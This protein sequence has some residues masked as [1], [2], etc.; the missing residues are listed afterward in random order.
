MDTK[1]L[2]SFLFKIK[3]FSKLKNI[4]SEVANNIAERGVDIAK[5]EYG[6]SQ[7]VIL[8][9]E[10]TKE[11]NKLQIVAQGA[12]I[13]FDE[14]GTG[15]IGE[16]T[17]RG[18]LPTEPIEFESPKGFPQRTEGWVY[19]YPNRKTKILGGWF[20]GKVFHRGQVAQAQ[21]YNTTQQLKSEMASIAEN[22]IKG[23]TKA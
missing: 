15:L 19:Y 4:S 21:M 16:G 22:T 7:R 23:L 14:F 20:A 6:H 11:P 10:K 9:I 8:S 17:Y 5:A 2:E 12:G 13:A 1:A 3:R 18:N